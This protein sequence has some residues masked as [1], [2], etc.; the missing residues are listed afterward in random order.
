[1]TPT[2]VNRF[3]RCFTT[4]LV[5]KITFYVVLQKTRKNNGILWSFSFANWRIF[6]LPVTMIVRLSNSVTVNP[7]LYQ[8]WQ[9]DRKG[10]RA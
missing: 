7:Y 8:Q 6:M 5:N 10:G 3:P 1:M 9:A 4:P 2:G